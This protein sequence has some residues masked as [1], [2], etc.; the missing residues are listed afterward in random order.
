MFEDIMTSPVTC[1]I[2]SYM[3]YTCAKKPY[4][5]YLYSMISCCNLA[6]ELF[7][8]IDTRLDLV[9]GVHTYWDWMWC[10]ISAN[11]GFLALITGLVLSTCRDL[12]ISRV[13][14]QSKVFYPWKP[15]QSQGYLSI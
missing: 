11:C 12:D 13:C 7:G 10:K 6:G 2:P 15:Y 3:H 5:A 8:L 9:F 4:L 14:A 1:T